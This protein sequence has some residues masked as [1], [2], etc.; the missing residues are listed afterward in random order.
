EV[1]AM[2]RPVRPLLAV[3]A[4]LL[5]A[6]AAWPHFP[7]LLPES[8]AGE[9]DKPVTLLYQWG[10]P[11]EHQLFEAAP[12]KRLAVFAPDGTR[13]D[14]AA[15]LQ[16]VSLPGATQKPVTAFRLSFTPKQRGDHTFVLTAGPVWMEEEQ[17]F[18]QD[19][20]K[21]VLHVTTQNG[22]DAA[23]GQPF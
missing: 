10:H 22:W 1:F 11:F 8:P 3:A 7:M 4:L 19:S 6:P 9:R 14:L 15:G 12:P 16:K 20:V 21:V 13:T 23:T 2:P 5:A 18:Y 17:L